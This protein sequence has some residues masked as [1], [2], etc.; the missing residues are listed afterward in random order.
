MIHDLVN[1]IQPRVKAKQLDL[2]IDTYEVINENV[3]TVESELGNGSTF[4]V[5]LEL[6]LQTDT[7][8][9]ENKINELNGLRAMVV[10]DDFNTCDSAAKCS[11]SSEC[12]PNG[13]PRARKRCSEPRTLSKRATLIIHL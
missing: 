5:E 2:Y 13:R 4:T 6:L 12:A 3:I 7:E 1:I 9:S 11:N 8:E 10:D